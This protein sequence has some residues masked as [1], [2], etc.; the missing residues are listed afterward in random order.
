[1][2]IEI[3]MSVTAY[4]SQCIG[5]IIE[6]STYTGEVVKVNKKSIIVK[7]THVLAKRGDKVVSDTEYNVPNV[8]YTY[9]KTTEDGRIIYKS[10][11]KIYGIIE[12][13]EET[14]EETVEETTEEVVEEENTLTKAKE[15][16]A[17]I[18]TDEFNLTEE[19]KEKLCSDYDDFIK[20]YESLKK[21]KENVCPICGRTYTEIPAIS[22]EDNTTEICPDCGT[23]Q[24]IEIFT[25]YTDKQDEQEAEKK[26]TGSKYCVASIY[27]PMNNVPMVSYYAYQPNSNGSY[28]IGDINDEYVVWYDSE[29][30]ALDARRNA[31][32]CV[33]GRDAKYIPKFNK[34]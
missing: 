2:K 28:K 14:T 33:I 23:N 4:K 8:K 9:W 5:L 18:E 32:E 26:T 22:R 30:E 29:Q 21:E 6:S 1:M 25:K 16:S 19:E 34:K 27:I 15:E 24:A 31:C 20:Q 7:L 10:D 12:F 3:G 13:K 17:E 11:S